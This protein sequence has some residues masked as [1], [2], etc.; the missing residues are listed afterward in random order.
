M[1]KSNVY[2][3]WKYVTNFGDKKSKKTNVK[4]P[5]KHCIIT[6]KKMKYKGKPNPGNMCITIDKDCIEYSNLKKV[7]DKLVHN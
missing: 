6:I 5:P 7:C 3:T 4:I 1:L 2:Y